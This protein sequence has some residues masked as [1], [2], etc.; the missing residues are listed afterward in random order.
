MEQAA[1]ERQK[2]LAALRQG[3]TN[4]P[5]EESPQAVNTSNISGEE[6]RTKEADN[7]MNA[8]FTEFSKTLE[9]E[10]RQL[11]ANNSF[12]MESKSDEVNLSELAAA[13]KANADLKRDM[14]DKMS[15]LD[16]R[17]AAAVNQLIRQRIAVSK[18]EDITEK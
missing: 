11:L 8:T 3:K 12:S 2:R 16:E 6:S 18:T 9:E 17:T 14:I 13:K 7:S 10:A 5:N 1:F 4:E 15:S